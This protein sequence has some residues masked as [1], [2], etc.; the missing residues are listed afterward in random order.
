VGD[1]APVF[2]DDPNLPSFESQ[3]ERLAEAMI[4]GGWLDTNIDRVH[5]NSIGHGVGAAT[6]AR[7]NL[8]EVLAEGRSMTG[9]VGHGAP[10]AWTFQSLL[11]PSDIA[12]LNND[13]YPTLIGTLT[14]YT[15][16]FVSPHNDTVAHRFMNGYRLGGD[17]E[18]IYGAPN[19]SVAIHGAATLSNYLQN[20]YFAERVIARQLEGATLGD[21]IQ[22]TRVEAAERGVDDLVINWVLLGD[23]TLRL[24]VQ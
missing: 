4:Q 2:T 8:F 23:P 14:C 20:E 7:S 24:S 12:D 11:F 6:E 19:G 15:S 18:P 3:A 21:A 10:S 13:G 16:Y 22:Q 9:F 5:M 17:G 1:Q